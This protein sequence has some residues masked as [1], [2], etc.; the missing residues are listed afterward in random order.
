MTTTDVVVACP[1]CDAWQLEYPDDTPP[2]AIDAVI[3]DHALDDCH[4]LLERIVRAQL[5]RAQEAPTP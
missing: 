1:G 4:P 5:A 2:E 3:L